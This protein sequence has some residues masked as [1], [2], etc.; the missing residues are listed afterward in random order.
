[1]DLVSSVLYGDEQ[2]GDVA[3]G[4]FWAFTSAG[5][6]IVDPES[7]K[8]ERTLT[9]GPD[10]AFLPSQWSDG[11][12]MER[13]VEMPLSNDRHRGL[14]HPGKKAGLVMINS[15]ITI[16]DGH[17]NPGGGTGEVYAISTDPADYDDPVKSVVKVG[18]RPV[19]SYAVYPQNEFWTH[20]D[21]TGEFFVISLD[22]LDQHSGDPVAAKVAEAHHGKLLW[23]EST[24]L[25]KHGFATST[26]ERFLFV[27]D[28]EDKTQIG[29][30]NFTS[31][32]GVM[33]YDS[34]CKGLHAIAYSEKNEHVYT[35]CSAG[36]GTLEFD[37]SDPENPVFVHQHKDATGALYETPGKS[38]PITSTVSTST[39]LA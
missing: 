34:Y 31:D 22:D 9:K 29:A 24:H 4:R 3:G 12:Y 38:K 11:V 25:Q 7:C 39:V 33:P 36:G 35:E 6:A 15:G 5:I 17:E 1:L 30:Y 8:V 23:D 21:L 2:Y 16:E 28:M 27:L 20:S 37:V 14:S 18:G 32:L 10:G 19:H 26:G 13:E